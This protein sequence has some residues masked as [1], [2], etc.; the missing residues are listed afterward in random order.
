MRYM[1]RPKKKL[2]KTLVYKVHAEVEKTAKHDLFSVR[3]M[4]R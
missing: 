4:L 1:L 3:Y 2:S